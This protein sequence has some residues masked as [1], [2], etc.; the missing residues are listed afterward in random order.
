MYDSKFILSNTVVYKGRLNNNIAD[1]PQNTL[2]RSAMTSRS[3][4]RRRSR[5]PYNAYPT[6][7]RGRSLTRSL[8]G[9]AARRAGRALAGFI[10][11][12]RTAMDVGGMLYDAAQH[13]RRSRSRSTARSAMDT[14]SDFVPSSSGGGRGRA[15]GR[16]GGT[17]KGRIKPK[18]RTKPGFKG[19]AQ[20]KGFS[21][22]MEKGGTVNDPYCAYVGHGCCPQVLMRRLMLGC[23]LKLLLRRLGLSFSNV[24]QPLTYLTASD[25]IEILFKLNAEDVNLQTCSLTLAGSQPTFQALLD[26]LV[27]QWVQAVQAQTF[28]SSIEWKLVEMRFE[29]NGIS[30]LTAIRIPLEN[31]KISF[32]AVSNL[33]VQN[34]SVPSAEDDADDEVDRIPVSGTIYRFK[35]MGSYFKRSAV[36]VLLEANFEPMG[37]KQDGLFT[38]SAAVTGGAVTLREPPL[39]YNFVRCISHGKVYLDPGVIKNSIVREKRTMYLSTLLRYVVGTNE[40]ATTSTTA[41]GSPLG[42]FNLIAVEKLIETSNVTPTQLISLAYEMDMKIFGYIT[43]KF[44]DNT[45]GESYFG[46]NPN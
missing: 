6:P 36:G 42:K 41:I 23:L 39:P 37:E 43:T 19:K 21:I 1:A 20:A 12:A 11:G 45:I 28:Q 29:P 34:R 2:K 5:S 7:E 30:D 8:A 16:A 44:L 25:K 9:Y 26:L 14:S 38:Y 35:G 4:T 15:F 32:E 40:S 17:Y 10:P 13:L 24:A 33:K 27:N 31:A 3:L 22:H 18:R 46:N